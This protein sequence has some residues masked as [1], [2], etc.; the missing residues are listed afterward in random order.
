MFDDLTD[1]AGD[2]KL[3]L[4]ELEGII[5]RGLRT[6]TDVGF[7]LLQIRDGKLYQPQYGS[8]EDY[9]REKWDL[10]HSHAYRLMDS[11]KVMA[12][13]KTSPIG[14]VLPTNESQTR[15]LASL[16]PEQQVEAWKEATKKAP[17]GKKPSARLVQKIVNRFRPKAGKEKVRESGWTAD[18]LKHD[19]EL[20]EALKA[21]AAVYGNEDTKAIRIGIGLIRSEILYLSKL[22]AE[23]MRSIQDLVMANHWTPKHALR[24]VEKRID[25]DTRLHDLQLRCLRTKD[26]FFSV[27]VGGFTHTC[28]ATCK[29]PPIKPPSSSVLPVKIKLIT[30]SLGW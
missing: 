7:A 9:C 26:K 2:K 6:F 23:K 1:K 15:P 14:E 13:L 12:N 17:T 4:V 27:V 30:S 28:E 19:P 3:E 8:F 24:F 16:S 22:P 5:E 25:G 20:L 11:A 18:E 21:I 29:A 10:E